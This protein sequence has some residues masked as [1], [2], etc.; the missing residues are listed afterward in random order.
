MANPIINLASRQM[1]READLVEIELTKNKE[2]AISTMIKLNQGNLSIP[3][4]SKIYKTW[5][6]THPPTEERIKFFE[7]YQYSNR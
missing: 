1:E 5:Y 7:D 6:H 2:A 4:P 3:R